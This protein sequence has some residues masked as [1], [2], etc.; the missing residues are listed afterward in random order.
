MNDC[1]V[2]V[3]TRHHRHEQ[4]QQRRGPPHGGG[5]HGRRG[6][7]RGGRPPRAGQRQRSTGHGAYTACAAVPT[8][9]AQDTPSAVEQAQHLWV[10]V[11]T[12]STAGVCEEP[13]LRRFDYCAQQGW[14]L[15]SFLASLAAPGGKSARRLGARCRWGTTHARFSMGTVRGMRNVLSP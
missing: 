11:S 13:Q 9:A 4:Q 15:A 5:A 6:E 10:S 8:H 3:S 12:R 14:R 7:R 1:E 2:T